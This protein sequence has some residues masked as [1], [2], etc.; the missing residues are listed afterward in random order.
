MDVVCPQ[1]TQTHSL[2]HIRFNASVRPT[3]S[4]LLFR[5]D[6]FKSDLKFSDPSY[7]S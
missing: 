2:Q 5:A 6:F 3:R 1:Q 7:R 4:S